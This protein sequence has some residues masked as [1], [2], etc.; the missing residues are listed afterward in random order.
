MPSDLERIQGYLRRQARRGRTPQALAAF[1]VYA[2]ARHDAG[3]APYAIPRRLSRPLREA[4]LDE[5]HTA[6]RR[7]G[8]HPQVELLAE[9]LADLFPDL[10]ARLVAAGYRE[11]QRQPALRAHPGDIHLPPAP[12]RAE[13]V[14]LSHTSSLAEARE[15]WET[16]ARGFGETGKPSEQ[17]VEAFRA[18]LMEGRAFTLRVDG[19]PVAAGMFEAIRGGVTELLGIATLPEERRRGYAAYLTAAMAESAF[20]HGATLVFLCAASD[21]AGRVYERVGLR[22]CTALVEYARE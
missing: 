2:P 4:D 12:A 10:L 17:E 11:T 7:H 13:L 15:G 14:T 1:T 5:L 16:N 22:R 6:F 8:A 21:E 19:R 9:F 20:A 18:G 3:E